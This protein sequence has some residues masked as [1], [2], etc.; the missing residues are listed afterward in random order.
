MLKTPYWLSRCNSH[1]T[2]VLALAPLTLGISLLVMTGLPVRANPVLIQQGGYIQGGYIQTI[3]QGG[4]IPGIQQGGY[5]QGGYIPGIPQSVYNQG[6]Q[7]SPLPYIYGSPI[8]SPIPLNSGIAVTNSH[9]NYYPSPN[10]GVGI[11]VP[12]P[13]NGTI[14]NSTLI[15]PTIVNSQIRDSVLVNPVIVNPTGYPRNHVR[16]SRIIY[17]SP[18]LQIQLGY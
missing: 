15:N 13:V 10:Y 14:Q 7:Q 18:N 17:G 2:N 4:Y 8:P 1:R 12:V 6:I 16:R 11:G 9:G 5:I 3:P